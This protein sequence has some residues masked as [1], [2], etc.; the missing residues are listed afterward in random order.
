MSKGDRVLVME[1]MKMQ[2]AI[3]APVAGKVT[4]KL[5]NAGDKVGRER[6]PD[7]DWVR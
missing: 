3:Y 1:A 7:R 5:V 2:S 6:S 4:Q